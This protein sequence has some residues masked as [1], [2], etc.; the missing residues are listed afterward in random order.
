VTHAVGETGSAVLTPA[1]HRL[2]GDDNAA[3][4]QEQLAIPQADAKHMVQP[5]GVADNLGGEAMAVGRRIG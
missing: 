2:V 5:H 4:S 3:F 1:S